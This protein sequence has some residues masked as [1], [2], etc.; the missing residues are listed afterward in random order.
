MKPNNQNNPPNKNNAKNQPKVFDVL[1]PGAAAP[2]SSA[3]PLVVTHRPMVQDPMVT[4]PNSDEENTGDTMSDSKQDT[5]LKPK[6]IKLQPSPEAIQELAEQAAAEKPAA[7]A[8]EPDADAASES[9]VPAEP[10]GPPDERALQPPAASKV[11]APKPEGAPESD[12]SDET[13]APESFSETTSDTPE[14]P[15]QTVAAEPPVEETPTSEQTATMSRPQA[16]P[17]QPKIDDQ[18]RP[19]GK[20][21]KPDAAETARRAEL[22]SAID[23]KQYFVHIAAPAHRRSLRAA[24]IGAVVII[25]VAVGC[26]DAMLDAGV[27]TISGI[28]HTHFI[29]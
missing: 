18:P 26:V 5:I 20:S 15:N 21:E 14:S 1:R 23:S 22:E 12:S 25:I 4:T 9:D 10:A 19:T 8:T 24:V 3:R 28:P 17:S 2:S 27:M 29:K 13:A 6:K 7:P 16:Q 11:A